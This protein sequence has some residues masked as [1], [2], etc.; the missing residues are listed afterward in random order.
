HAHPYRWMQKERVAVFSIVVIG[1]YQRICAT[2]VNTAKKSR[3]HV[4]DHRRDE[5]ERK[6][7]DEKIVEGSLAEW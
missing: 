7:H 2:G 6:H 5:K 4:G 3:H 1:L